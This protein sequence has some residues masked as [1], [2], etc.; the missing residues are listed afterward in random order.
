M[1]AMA[2][3]GAIMILYVSLIEGFT[4]AMVRNMI[5]NSL[6]DMQIHAKGYLDDPDLYTLVPDPDRLAERL[7]ASGY[8]AA[9][10]WY[11]IGLAA[12]GES[13]A[14]V[15]LRGV[16][17]TR[18]RTVTRTHEHVARGRWLDGAEPKGAV[19]GRRL[20]RTLNVD[21]G[22]EIVFLSQAADGSLANELF[23]VRGVLKTVSE[24]VDRAG[25]FI[26]RETFTELMLVDDA[27]SEI[28]VALPLRETPLEAATREA[29]ALAPGLEVKNWRALSPV[30]AK[31]VDTAGAGT[32]IMLLIVYSAIGMVV[33]NAMLMNVFERIREYGIMKALGMGPWRVAGLVY[34]EAALTAL[35]ACAVAALGGGALSWWAQTSGIDLSVFGAGED[36]ATFGGMAFDP[37]WYARL[38]PASVIRPLAALAAVVMIAALYPCVKAA[39]IRP[40]E[41]IHHR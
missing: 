38:T 15:T 16:D 12:S 17:L 1:G 41:A 23:I 39:V 27:A 13:S 8:H 6:G 11:G 33:L 5:S 26:P 32:Y 29:A 21:V 36:F 34:A 30:M 24:P 14:A 19:I 20:A 40:V 37:V 10:R 2:F 7:E 28:A 4:D 9:P 18:E 22:D 31:M 3:A 25:F 35:I